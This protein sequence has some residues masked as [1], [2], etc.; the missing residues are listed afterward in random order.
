LAAPEQPH[1][2]AVRRLNPFLGV[3]EV[4]DIGHARALSVD[5]VA[6]QIQIRT[7]R[8]A[9]SWGT[10]GLA[11]RVRR[12]Y[13]FGYWSQADGLARTPVNPELDLSFLLTAW[14]QL[15]GVLP[16]CLQ[17]LP[18]PL[19]DRYE[20]WL[21]DHDRRPLALLSSAV[22]GRYLRE[23]PPSQWR[24]TTPLERGFEAGALAQQAPPDADTRHR[25][26]H[27]ERLEKQVRD[28]AGPCQWILRGG[29]GNG[30]AVEA[31]TAS[32]VSGD[33]WAKSLFPQLTVREVW[34]DCDAESLVAEWVG[35]LAP[36]LLTLQ[37]LDDA[38]R[39]RLERAACARAMLVE[40]QYRLYPRIIDPE[41]VNSARVEARLR[42]AAG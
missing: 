19:E 23:T 3:A 16:G 5:G 34:G 31:V 29:D 40:D 33:A 10:L 26:Q 25:Q 35:W 32:L 8:P 22:D 1:C 7:E 4:V 28:A 11:T 39:A 9:R 17:R 14:E 21:L 36:R 27:A 20:C 24:V 15:S 37:D 30:S 6:W 38:T 13:R 12:Y 2:F 18:F 41:T 42:Q